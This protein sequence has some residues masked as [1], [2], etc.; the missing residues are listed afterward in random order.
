MHKGVFS[1]SFSSADS[2]VLFTVSWITHTS[3]IAAI[4]NGYFVDAL[5]EHN[6]NF[7]IKLYGMCL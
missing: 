3:W 2:E 7:F 6:Y 5:L 1:K 4:I